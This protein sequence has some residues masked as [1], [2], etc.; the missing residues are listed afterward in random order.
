MT[1]TRLTAADVT[2][3]ALCAVVLAVLVGGGW[4]EAGAQTLKTW[5]CGPFDKPS[6][7]K[8]TLTNGTLRISGAGV[9]DEKPW[10]E[11][12][13]SITDLIIEEGV[14]SIGGGVFSRLNKLKSVI[15]PSS[16]TSIG[17]Y[18]FIDCYSLKTLT[19]P[20][21]L[22]SIEKAVFYKCTSLTSITI[23]IGMKSIGEEAFY[24]CY[25]LKSITIPGSVKSIGENAFA[26]CYNLTSVTI[27][28][29]V[30][31]IG[32]QAFRSCRGLTSITI[33]GSVKSIGEEAFDR[34]L[35]MTSITIQSGVT[36]IG[37]RVFAACTSLTSITIP[38][39]MKFI[40]ERA[41]SECIALTSIIIPGSVTSIGKR[42]FYGCSCLTSINVDKDNRA[43]S[44]V[45]GVFFNKAQST[46]IQYPRAK[47]G[48][49]YTIPNNV[50]TIGVEAFA[51]CVGLTS[52]TF[53]GSV[54]LVEEDAFYYCVN[55]TSI[56]VNKD[57]PAYSSIDGV[58]FNKAQNTLIQY[59][60]AKQSGA[61]T[62]PDGVTTIGPLAFA[63]CVVLTS[64]TI[65]R[66]VT[67]LGNGAFINCK[68][69]IS[70]T[71]LNPVPPVIEGGRAFGS[72]ECPS[73]TLYVPANS[74]NAYWH[75]KGWCS[76]YVG[77][78]SGFKK[79][80]KIQSAGN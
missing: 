29:G 32:K 38:N 42:A 79:I 3:A 28:N 19:L 69:P 37:N 5:D 54:K 7:V 56:N 52:I 73:N 12:K 27:P 58:L 45:D 43:Y 13:H 18:A 44:S 8:A 21:N 76:E 50:T 53:P 60:I 41:F 23:P 39:S 24:G 14:T 33:P 17:E 20:N 72:N 77:N 51:G 25:N 67:K 71:S 47:Q 16:V 68:I 66:S 11:E 78:T 74:I 55:L 36:S 46:L 75:A 26:I 49:T 64:V 9:V 40:G 70:A 48:G 1:T 35:D 6:T 30:E 2:R 59:P 22:K 31:S 10:G 57:N 65:P 34:C 63:R 61:Y 80:E 15:I 4:G 62:I